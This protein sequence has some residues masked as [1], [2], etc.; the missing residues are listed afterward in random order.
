MVSKTVVVRII[1]LLKLSQFALQLQ[2][3][4]CQVSFGLCDFGAHKWIAKNWVK[5]YY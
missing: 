1:K 5:H 4:C 3:M 2:G